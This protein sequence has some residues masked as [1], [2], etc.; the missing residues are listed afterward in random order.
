[1]SSS[2]KMDIDEYSQPVVITKLEWILLDIRIGLNCISKFDDYGLING[3]DFLTND[4]DPAIIVL[5]YLNKTT[6]LATEN[7][8]IEKV[9]TD[10]MNYIVG[11][12][13][14]QIKEVDI[15]NDFV[16]NYHVI[17]GKEIGRFENGAFKFL[18]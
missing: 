15:K 10:K 6:Y 2:A 13:K 1:M 12:I 3:V 9:L 16:G 8:V 4:K 18:K 11:I 14:L 7:H 17:D 5:F